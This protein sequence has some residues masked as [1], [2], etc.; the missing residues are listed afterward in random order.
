M[1]CSP[2]RKKY[3]IDFFGRI[4]V[5]LLSFALYFFWPEC[6]SVMEGMNFFR[7]LSPLHLLWCLWM[8]HMI[9]Q[10]LPARRMMALGSQ[11]FHPKLF[12]KG[13]YP[14]ADAFRAFFRR[15]NQGA[16]KVFVV[17]LALTAALG[18]LYLTRV[19]DAKIMLLLSVFF[20]LCDL[21]CV[22]I[23]C[24][25]RLMM[26]NRCCTTCRIFN[27]D[28]LMMFSIMVFIPGFFSLTLFFMSLVVF[29]V[30]EISFYLR[31]DFFW[32]RT[33]KALRCSAC[34]DKL[35]GNRLQKQK[36]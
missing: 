26:R 8:G 18:V 31:P 9:I 17:W 14:N 10:L 4:L 25:F 29:L 27:W 3:F 11:K 12:V 5:V 21:I 19:I 22:L 34:T 28:H 16:L 23:W 33:N 13:D 6:F 15:S 1:S 35:C 2:M 36:K 7:Q 32:D 30:W 24:P 20:Y